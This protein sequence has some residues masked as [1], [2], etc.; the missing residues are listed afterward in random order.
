MDRKSFND[1]LLGKPTATSLQMTCY[2]ICIVISGEFFG[3]NLGLLHGFKNMAL[4]TL[5]VTI[6]I[7]CVIYVTQNFSR[8]IPLH[9]GMLVL[10]RMTFG[11]SLSLMLGLS[12]FSSECFLL[13]LNLGAMGYF[14]LAVSKIS[15][16]TFPVIAFFVVLFTYLTNKSKYYLKACIYLALLTIVLIVICIMFGFTLAKL[17]NQTQNLSSVDSTPISFQRFILCI[18]Y[19]LWWYLGIEWGPE[20]IEEVVKFEKNCWKS[21]YW[22]MIILNLLVLLILFVVPTIPPYLNQYQ[23]LQPLFDCMAFQAGV[24]PDAP[25]GRAIYT[26]IMVPAILAST[27]AGAHAAARQVYGLSRLGLITTKI[28]ITKEGMPVFSSMLSLIFGFFVLIIVE[29]Y[30]KSSNLTADT[31]NRTLLSLG[32]W[33]AFLSYFLTSF[34]CFFAMKKYPVFFSPT[35]FNFFITGT[36]VFL[37]FV[38]L[39]LSLYINPAF[40]GICAII[41]LSIFVLIIFRYRAFPPQ[42]TKNPSFRYFQKKFNK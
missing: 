40:F 3:W 37:S 17:R 24:N 14:V 38:V 8:A 12:L 2:L 11:P 26:F 30:A 36:C 29:Y 19:S 9:G 5:Y 10:T 23:S 22:A 31:L 13:A 25:W 28:S 42:F 32:S 35:L 4:A 27:T 1:R 41:T 7:W 39:C 15:E 6:N 34:S 18:P 16:Q 21:T 20:L 33:T